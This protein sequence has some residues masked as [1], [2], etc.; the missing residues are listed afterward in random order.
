MKLRKYYIFLVT[1][2]PSNSTQ[3]LSG[4]L[5][6]LANRSSVDL[7]A[8]DGPKI[9]QNSPLG[10]SKFNLSTAMM[11]SLYFLLTDLNFIT[12]DYPSNYKK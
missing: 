5:I 7:P 2:L 12:Y 11:L 3:P 1:L 9:T 6:P 4:I 10:I 8:P